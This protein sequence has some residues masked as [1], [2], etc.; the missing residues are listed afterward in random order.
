LRATDRTID[1][2]DASKGYVIGNVVACCYA[3]NHMKSLVENDLAGTGLTGLKVVRK[4]FDKTIKR[5][6]KQTN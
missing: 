4:V 2:V 6:E 3:V 5:I 1:R